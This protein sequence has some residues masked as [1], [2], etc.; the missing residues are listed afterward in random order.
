VIPQR[1]LTGT[2]LARRILGLIADPERRARMAQAVHRLARP[3][4]ASLIVDRALQ[5]VT[6]SRDEA[7]GSGPAAGER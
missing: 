1:T 4:A 7:A 3:D 5:L 2:L 6:R